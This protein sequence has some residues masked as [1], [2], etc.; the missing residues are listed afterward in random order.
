MYRHSQLLVRDNSGLISVK[1]LQL[2]PTSNK[3]GVV[4]NIALVTL[5]KYLKLKKATRRKTYFV[6]L[7]TLKRWCYRNDG[8]YFFKF[9]LN[10]C[11]L[12]NNDK[13]RFVG[14]VFNVP[15]TRELKQYSTLKLTRVSTVLI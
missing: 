2:Y 10:T 8:A 7:T 6:V 14:T 1:L 15:I 11:L 4:G 5:L 12:L 3:I 13:E 9:D